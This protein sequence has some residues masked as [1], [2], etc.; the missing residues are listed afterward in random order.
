[1]VKT[2]TYIKVC[3][4]W[5]A[6]LIFFEVLLPRQVGNEF[7]RISHQLVELQ[8]DLLISDGYETFEFGTCTQWIQVSLDETN[9]AFDS[10]TYIFDPV[11]LR[12][13]MLIHMSISEVFTIL[14]NHVFLM[15]IG[16]VRQTL[17]YV[18]S[19]FLHELAEIGCCH[20]DRPIFPFF[21]LVLV[22]T[23][24]R[25]FGWVTQP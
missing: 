20:V 5:F 25:S 24:E 11:S 22:T 12:I 7:L 14:F 17:L 2:R 21:G 3:E 10:G 6:E 23:H 13:L 4:I 1:M 9:V 8:R 16:C 19:N 15:I 18:I